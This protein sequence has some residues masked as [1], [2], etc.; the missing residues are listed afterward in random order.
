MP[1]LKLF[2]MLIAYYAIVAVAVWAG[3]TLYPPLEGYLPVGHIQALVAEAGASPDLTKAVVP[4]A[5][6]RSLWGSLVWLTSAIV[7][8][9]VVAL[10]V[11]RVY[12]TIRNPKQYDQSLVD[13]IVMLPMVVTTVVVIVQDSLALSFSLAGIAGAARFR[14]SMKASGDL[15]FVLLSIAIGLAAGIGAME[16]AFIA[17]IAFNFCLVALWS[18][19]YGERSEMKR[20]MAGHHPEQACEVPPATAAPP[21]P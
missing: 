11:S 2:A 8:A 6:V 18:S 1:A 16:L 13:T 15:L 21:Q 10:P 9:L 19:N 7:G 12:L 17:T 20:Y 5:P 4:V 3:V 14:N